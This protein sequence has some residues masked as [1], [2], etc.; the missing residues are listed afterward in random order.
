MPYRKDSLNDHY[1]NP[2][3]FSGLGS[4]WMTSP[5]ILQ[6]QEQLKLLQQLKLF[7]HS[8]TCAANS[9][10]LSMAILTYNISNSLQ[11]CIYLNELYQYKH[12]HTE[13]PQT[14]VMRNLL[15]SQSVKSPKHLSVQSWSIIQCLC[16]RVGSGT[17]IASSNIKAAFWSFCEGLG[18]GPHG[19]V[20]IFTETAQRE[21]NLETHSA[22]DQ[23]LKFTEVLLCLRLKLLDGGF[24]RLPESHIVPLF[25]WSWKV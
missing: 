13:Q 21:M 5:T 10:R 4:A 16:G 17:E 7:K 3:L 14:R 11:F 15:L 12:P 25:F 18:V 8:H 24:L 1:I 23:K 22:P 19:G 2:F 6:G 20:V 9:P